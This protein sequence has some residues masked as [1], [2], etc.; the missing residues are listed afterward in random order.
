MHTT[1]GI[2]PLMTPLEDIL[3]NKFIPAITGRK[4]VT[5]EERQL[6]ALLCKN[7]GLGIINPTCVAD[8]QYDASIDVTKPLVELILE[9]K[10]EYSG[11]VDFKQTR[12][13]LRIKQNRR[14]KYKEEMQNM[15]LPENLRRST[16]LH[17]E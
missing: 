4:A 9:Q 8:E 3:R 1:P 13:K 16:E 10:F 5:N 6:L 17:G 7:G 11:D 15:T 2:T 12:R 14:Q